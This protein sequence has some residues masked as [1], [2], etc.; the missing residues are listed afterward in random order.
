[1]NWHKPEEV[2]RL[3]T[4]GVAGRDGVGEAEVRDAV[5]GLP[6]AER[7]AF[8]D[9]PV[10]DASS[11]MVRERVAAGRPFQFLV[12]ERVAQRIEEAGLYRGGG[13]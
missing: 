7:I 4:L 12:P 13:G 9:M 3:A 1:V 8:F 11:T 10:I 2:L 6:G 5:E